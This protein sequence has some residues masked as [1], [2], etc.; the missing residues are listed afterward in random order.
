VRGL[1]IA[2]AKKR[3]PILICMRESVKKG[4]DERERRLPY[5]RVALPARALT[6]LCCGKEQRRAALLSPQTLISH[7]PQPPTASSRLLL[8]GVLSR[9]RAR[10][11]SRRGAREQEINMSPHPTH[12]LGFLLA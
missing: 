11:D 7:R 12:F 10:E 3:R 6:K 8:R 4:T 5:A 1:K 9:V 2:R